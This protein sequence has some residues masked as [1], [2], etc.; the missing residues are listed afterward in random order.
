MYNNR[1]IKIKLSDRIDGIA[2]LVERQKHMFTLRAKLLGRSRSRFPNLQGN[3]KP[4]TTLPLL[5]QT[6]HQKSCCG[7]IWSAGLD[8]LG[9]SRVGEMCGVDRNRNQCVKV[10]VG[11]EELYTIWSEG[12]WVDV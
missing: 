9:D 5:V 6:Q 7:S 11:T 3:Q 12:D 2:E 10:D 4:V 8:S 1:Q